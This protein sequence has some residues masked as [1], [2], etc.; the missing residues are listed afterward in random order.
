M[1]FLEYSLNKPIEQEKGI[2]AVFENRIRKRPKAPQYFPQT[3]PGLS[4]F[5]IS[6]LLKIVFLFEMPKPLPEFYLQVYDLCFPASFWQ[7]EEL[8]CS[9]PKRSLLL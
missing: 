4:T 9:L 6:L 3:E 2:G 8:L 5:Q 7:V 1:D